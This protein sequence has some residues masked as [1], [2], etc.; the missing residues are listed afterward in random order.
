MRA[1]IIQIFGIVQGVGFRPF[2][3]REAQ[4][5]R[6]KGF[7]KNLGSSVVIKVE[8]KKKVLGVF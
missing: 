6:L 8:G 5:N 4:K 2:V 3:Y 1:Y 7:V